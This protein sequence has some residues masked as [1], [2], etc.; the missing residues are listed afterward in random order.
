M[1]IHLWEQAIRNRESRASTRRHE[2]V[3]NKPA[4]DP[5][6]QVQALQQGLTEVTQTLAGRV[7]AQ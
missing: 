1:R 6:S 5:C 7:S 2:A 3:Q 4:P